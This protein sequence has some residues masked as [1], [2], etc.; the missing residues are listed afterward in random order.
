MDAFPF[1]KACL[2]PLSGPQ[3][4][5]DF[6]AINF[7]IGDVLQPQYDLGFVAAS[8]IISVIGSFVA[9]YHARYLHRA[10]GTLNLSMLFGAAL[11]LGGIGIWTMHFVG[12]MGY[13]LPVRVV[14]DGFWT[15]LSLLAA[16]FIA[17]IALLLAGGKGKFSNTGW[18]AGSLLAGTGVCVMHYMGMY[19][20]NLR[21][22]MT[23]DMVTVL[24]SFVIAVTA[25]AAALWLAFHVVNGYLRIA[26]ALVMGLAVCAMH[27]TGMSAAQFV[28][29]AANAP[30]MWPIG[31]ALLPQIVY[32]VT[33]FVL[34]FLLWNL[35]GALGSKDAAPA[36]PSS[37]ATSR[38]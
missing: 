32:S 7:N 25:S 34:V 23:L 10:N 36:R 22:D 3:L 24:I 11:S 2:G 4:D 21:A 17:G 1:T 33:G 16:I 29:V 18:L 38:A 27:Y 12:M 9:L 19:A 14:Y 35:L 20:M 15:L 30:A 13:R 37:G 31:G 8:Y 6:M 28:C 26:A 5:G